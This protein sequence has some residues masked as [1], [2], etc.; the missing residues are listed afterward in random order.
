VSELRRFVAETEADALADRIWN[1]AELSCFDVEPGELSNDSDL[2]EANEL[3][4]THWASTDDVASV[5]QLLVKVGK[6]VGESPWITD[7]SE[8][9][10]VAVLAIDLELEELGRNLRA[11]VP[12]ATQHALMRPAAG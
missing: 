7:R 3:L 5:R 9:S 4:R 11:M 12:K 6:R 8:H 10:P 2:R 1:P